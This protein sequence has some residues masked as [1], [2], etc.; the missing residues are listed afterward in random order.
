MSE[1]RRELLKSTALVA[2]AAA[3]LQKNAQ[4]E[5]AA[6]TPASGTPSPCMKFFSAGFRNERIK[7]SGELRSYSRRRVLPNPTMTSQSKGLIPPRQRSI[8]RKRS[9]VRLN[10]LWEIPI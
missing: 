1:T 4:A 9:F 8:T 3:L 10:W 7:T 5:E 2:G 6:W